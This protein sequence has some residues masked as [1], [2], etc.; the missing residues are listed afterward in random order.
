MSD[1]NSA[2]AVS[3]VGGILTGVGAI[4]LGLAA[5][6]IAAQWQTHTS[7]SL[8]SPPT[9]R[10]GYTLVTEKEAAASEY[11]SA[12]YHYYL[13]DKDTGR[14]WAK[15]EYKDSWEEVFVEG[16]TPQDSPAASRK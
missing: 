5:L 10:S 1:S 16:L 7:I 9:A 8:E 2:V 3:R 11:S 15:S 12:K 6:T 4:L 13:L 14:I